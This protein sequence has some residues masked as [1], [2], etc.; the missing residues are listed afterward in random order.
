MGKILYSHYARFAIV[1]LL[2]Y[3]HFL[4]AQEVADPLDNI[5][6]SAA[7][8]LEFLAPEGRFA[9]RLEGRTLG[10]DKRYDDQGNLHD[11]G[12]P[13]DQVNLDAS[14]FPP[15]A[16][17]GA[18]ATLG[19]THFDTEVTAQ[20]YEISIGYG[21]HKDITV[22]AIIPFGRIS[23]HANFSVTGGNVGFNPAYDPTLPIGGAN[24]PLL[25]VGV[26]GTTPLG[27]A[28]VQVLLS[29]PDYGYG[30]KPIA[31][32]TC[33]GLADPTIGVIWRAYRT[34]RSSLILST[35]LRLGLAKEVNP[36][37]L[38]AVP[39]S[40]GTTDLRLRL[41]YYYDLGNNFDFKFQVEH[42]IQF[43]DHVTKRVPQA[44]QLLAP[45]SSKERLTRDT[46][47]YWEYDV[48]I[49]KVIGNWRAG[50][51]WHLYQK[52]ADTYTSSLGTNTSTLEANTLNDAQQWKADLSW[53]G[54]KAW[55][56]GDLPL[57][58]IV[59]LTVQETYKARNFPKVH[60]VFLQITSFF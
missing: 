25:P 27:T 29:D 32:S 12:E 34:K 47:D 7:H 36:D 49:G 22:G 8:G 20:R 1:T 16:P 53:S 13:L 45:S 33:S 60:D 51:T 15:L 54:I 50:L 48:G 24:V 18:G 52:E 10:Y 30:Y 4:Q 11:L 56:Q 59:Q 57:P 6:T 37:D 39:L 14:V 28:G 26:G 23:T 58:L 44:G 55:K 31:T 2:L 17:F 3:T 41:E 40:D 42:D 9:I 46:G 21:I 43:K 38:L 19:L 5:P 35:G